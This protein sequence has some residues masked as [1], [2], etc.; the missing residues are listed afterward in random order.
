MTK[1]LIVTVINHSS[2]YVCIVRR[3]ILRY[4]ITD[5]WITYRP[6]ENQKYLVNRIHD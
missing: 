6:I 2:T 4:K 5:I 3:T 1:R